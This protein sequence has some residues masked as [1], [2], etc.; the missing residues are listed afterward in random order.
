ME[1]SGLGRGLEWSAVTWSADVAGLFPRF[2]SLTDDMTVLP[3]EIRSFLDATRADGPELPILDFGGGS[4]ELVGAACRA[5][6]RHVLLDPVRDPSTAE[7]PR[8]SGFDALIFSHVLPFIPDPLALFAELAAYSHP[9]ARSLAIV[10]DDTG[11]QAEICREAATSDPHFLNYFGHA[12]RLESLLDS[13]GIPFSAH[14][15]VT[16]AVTRS[17]DDLLMV[18][19]FY[20]DGVIDELVERLAST[21][22]PESTGDYVLTTHHRVFAWR[23]TDR[24][25]RQSAQLSV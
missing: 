10:L 4:G 5:R 25:F 12:Q 21:L 6:D 17:H 24:K 23:S 7:L 11:T 2:R 22:T 13:A 14:T 19:A 18:V 8:G 1:G 20:L 9:D 15:V 3:A 16:R